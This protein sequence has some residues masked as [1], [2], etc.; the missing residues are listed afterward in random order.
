MKDGLRKVVHVEVFDFDSDTMAYAVDTHKNQFGY[1]YTTEF[2]R[3]GVL[4]KKEEE[5]N[6]VE[7]GAFYYKKLGLNLDQLKSLRRFI[8][9]IRGNKSMITFPN[10]DG[11]VRSVI[12]GGSSVSYHG[13]HMDD[14]FQKVLK[15]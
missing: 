8:K 1:K 3:K 6:N 12:R 10:E 7:K 14:Y 2:F 15:K 9:K 11:S 13:Q 4:I 5:V